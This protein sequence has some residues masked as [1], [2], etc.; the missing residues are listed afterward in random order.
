MAIS[1]PTKK[2]FSQEAR[3]TFDTGPLQ[4]LI[5]GYSRL[6]NPDTDSNST[7]S[8]D[9][10]R[11]LGLTNQVTAYLAYQLGLPLPTAQFSAGQ[12]R[13]VYPDRVFI[14]SQQLYSVDIETM[15]AFGD[16]SWKSRRGSGCLR[17]SATT[18]NGRR[19]RTAIPSPS[20]RRSRT[21]LTMQATRPSR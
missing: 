19:S 17:V 11:D 3:L 5:G 12:A 18:A 7:F 15:A 4:G 10:D 21:P 13:S 14:S 2:T 6:K 8:L 20:I 16:V 9:I 1:R